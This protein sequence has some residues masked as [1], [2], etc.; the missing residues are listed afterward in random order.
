MKKVLDFNPVL[1]D[2]VR[3]SLMGLL[4]NSS[5][6]VTFGD[7]L[8]ALSLT[9]G[10]LSSHMKRLEEEGLVKVKKE[11]VNRV[12]RTTYECTQSGRKE[13]KECL[14]QIQSLLSNSKG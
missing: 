3:M 4:A 7:L 9:K 1:A 11:F 2:R 13:L 6:P 5:E 14:V 8:E 10:N 12:P